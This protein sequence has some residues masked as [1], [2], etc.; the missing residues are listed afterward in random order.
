MV[1]TKIL[2]KIAKRAGDL[3]M[4]VYAGDE[5]QKELKSD[6]SPVTIADKKADAYIRSELQKIYADI[7]I[8]SEE[9]EVPAYEIRK[10]WKECFIVDPLDGT[11]EFIKKNG[12]FTVNIA[13]V[14]D[15]KTMEGVVYAPAKNLLYYTHEGKSYKG[16]SELPLP[17]VERAFQIVT[18]RSHINAE[19]LEYIE[20]QKKIYPD[21]ETIPV[22]S[23]LKLC[24]IAEGSADLYPRFG[25]TSEWDIAAAQAVVEQAGGSVV[26]VN[27]NAP[28]IYNKENLLNDWFE[29]RPRLPK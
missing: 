6:N 16:E 1:D 25:P 5:F 26:S 8:I 11:K 27:T 12:E 17:Q 13:Y 22:G 9:F 2:C 24:L 23:S 21:L 15:G 10:Q 19:T 28:L 4:E 14:R 20:N 29:V 3:I 18:S 7:P